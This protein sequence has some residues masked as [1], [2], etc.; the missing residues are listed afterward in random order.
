MEMSL[1]ERYSW[2]I[3]LSCS[4]NNLSFIW[5]A[6]NILELP[7]QF[8]GYTGFRQSLQKVKIFLFSLRVSFVKYHS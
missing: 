6:N 1:L 8:T 7:S 5:K 3:F 4:K 2:N